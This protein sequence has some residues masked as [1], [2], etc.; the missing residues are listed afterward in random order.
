MANRSIRD[1]LEPE[2]ARELHKLEEGIP[3]ILENLEYQK[4][5]IRRLADKYKDDNNVGHVKDLKDVSKTTNDGVEY[6]YYEDSRVI[7]D[8]IRSLVSVQSMA[9]E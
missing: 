6:R 3:D 9:S 8:D 4:S 2:Q 1:R 5:N 7:D